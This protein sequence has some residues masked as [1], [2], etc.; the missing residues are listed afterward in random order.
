MNGED[1]FGS[2]IRVIYSSQME[3]PNGK[4][5]PHQQSQSQVKGNSS[6]AQLPLQQ[7]VSVSS[8]HNLQGTN[9]YTA[10]WKPTWA[11]PPPPSVSDLN[12][13]QQNNKALT[14]SPSHSSSGSLSSNKSQTESGS[15]SAS[16]SRDSS[17]EPSPASASAQTSSGRVS[18]LSFVPFSLPSYSFLWVSANNCT[19]L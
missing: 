10:T 5:H 19:R 3:F 16:T 15:G 18:L 17:R 7:A 4:G 2:K 13:A 8:V 6:Q 11:H 14:P 12:L 1:V 9:S